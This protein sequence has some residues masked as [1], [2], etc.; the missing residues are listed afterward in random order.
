MTTWESAYA[1]VYNPDTG[2]YLATGDLI[3]TGSMGYT[4]T[5]LMNG[6]VLIAGGD[7]NPINSLYDPA[8]GKFTT[9]R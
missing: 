9:K 4:A 7:T 8:T 6:N 1:E 2:T 5:L 3:P